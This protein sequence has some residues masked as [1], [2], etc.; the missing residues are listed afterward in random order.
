VCFI[1]CGLSKGRVIC[2]R[3]Q[4]MNTFISEKPDNKKSITIVIIRYKVDFS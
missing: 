2:L 4:F 1:I 3:R